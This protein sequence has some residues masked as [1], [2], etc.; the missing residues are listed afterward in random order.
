MSPEPE[1]KYDVA[2]SFLSEDQELACTIQDALSSGLEVFLYTHRQD[3]IA[4][5]D[6]LESFRAV[7]RQEARIVVILYRDGWGQTPWTQ[8]EKQAI[9][10]RFLDEGPGFLFVV[11]LNTTSTPPLWLPHTLI[12]FNLSDYSVEQAV[13]AIQYRAQE[14]G[15]VIRRETIA[16]RARRSQQVTEFAQETQHLR[17]SDDGVKAVREAALNFVAHASQLVEEA[18]RAA[19]GLGLEF[20]SNDC[21]V[22]I[23]SQ[24]LSLHAHWAHNPFAVSIDKSPLKVTLF[25][26]P[27]FLPVERKL[28]LGPPDE[29]DTREYHPD[30]TPAM[31][32]C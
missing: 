11:M 6:G 4:G 1:H 12:R 10:D 16:D 7:F 14:A 2:I 32:W 3:K 23:R 25:N 28:L 19:S 27:I 31:G 21:D 8:V 20:G 24:N 5:T 13:G 22:A 30:R 18:N 9:T 26:G 15:S 29:L 17:Y